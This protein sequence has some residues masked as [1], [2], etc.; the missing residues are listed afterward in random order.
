MHLGEKVVL[1]LDESMCLVCAV[2]LACVSGFQCLIYVLWCGCHFARF[3]MGCVSVLIV[4]CVLSLDVMGSVIVVK[5][6]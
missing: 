1:F 2:G 3:G 5:L 6:C 4:L